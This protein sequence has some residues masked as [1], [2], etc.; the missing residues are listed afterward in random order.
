MACFLDSDPDKEPQQELSRVCP[1]PLEQEEEA[2][3]VLAPATTLPAPTVR[4]V[5]ATVPEVP[6]M[7]SSS[8]C[9]KSRSKYPNRR[10]LV[11]LGGPI[12]AMKNICAIVAAGQSVHMDVAVG[13]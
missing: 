1:W 5:V 3:A 2:T 8:R 4:A 9:G 7:A 6:T 11:D 13:V 10:S 12:W